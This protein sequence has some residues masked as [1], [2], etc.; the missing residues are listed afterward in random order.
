MESFRSCDLS[1]SDSDW[2]FGESKGF[3][4]PQ[5]AP[6][7]EMSKSLGSQQ[8]RRSYPAMDFMNKT[9]ELLTRNYS[10]MNNMDEAAALE[11]SAL[12]GQAADALTSTLSAHSLKMLG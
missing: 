5:Q 4:S 11:L 8:L 9:D 2:G 6:E 1:Q 3:N 7:G 12:T 10:T